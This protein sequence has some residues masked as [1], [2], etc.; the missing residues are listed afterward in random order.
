MDNWTWWPNLY[1]KSNIWKFLSFEVYSVLAPAVIINEICQ[2]DLKKCADTTQFLHFTAFIFGLHS[3]QTSV[4]ITKSSGPDRKE[5]GTGRWQLI[6]P[7]FQVIDVRSRTIS[8]RYII[9]IY[10]YYWIFFKYSNVLFKL[11]QSAYTAIR[12]WCIWTWTFPTR[13]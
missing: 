10:D 9:T 2:R 4:Y 7:D 5:T 12:S 6:W 3:N 1:K 13:I 8:A 11:I